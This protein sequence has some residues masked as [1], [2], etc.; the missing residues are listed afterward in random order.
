MRRVSVALYRNDDIVHLI[1][2]EMSI[3]IGDAIVID[4]DHVVGIVLHLDRIGKVC[5][6]QDLDLPHV[7]IIKKTNAGMMGKC[8][9]FALN[10]I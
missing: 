10:Q 7:P 3:V 4:L 6:N 5:Q 1:L 9:I 8:H 2:Q